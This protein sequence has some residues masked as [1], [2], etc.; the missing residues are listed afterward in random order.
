MRRHLLSVYQDDEQRG[1]YE[2]QYD[3]HLEFAG[4]GN[5]AAHHVGIKKECR[6]R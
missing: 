3:D 4:A 2:S 1:T 6:A 5:D